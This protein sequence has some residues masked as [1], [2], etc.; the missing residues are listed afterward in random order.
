[1]LTYV[2]FL[3]ERMEIWHRKEVLHLSKP[4]TDDPV[5]R[6]AS[7]CNIYRELDTVTRFEVSLLTGVPRTDVY[8]ICLL[9][10]S[11]SP[12][13]Y[14]ALRAGT[15]GHLDPTKVV[16]DSMVGWES[17]YPGESQ[18]GWVLSFKE[19]LDSR[20]DVLV[21]DIQSCREAGD[22]C[23]VI[24]HSLDP[25]V[26]Y[27][28]YP[29]FYEF[30]SYEIY[31]SLT[32]CRWF[33]FTEDDFCVIGPGCRPALERL[34]RPGAEWPEFENLYLRVRDR[35]ETDPDFRWIPPEYQPRD[36]T[37]RKFTRRTLEHSLCEWRKYFQICEGRPPRRAYNGAAS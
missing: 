6:R 33:P 1:M 36:P 21:D 2:E 31:T 9:R 13:T 24:S 25:G 19:Q 22:V 3:K 7:F 37:P 11:N 12:D 5:L 10:H 18:A 16:D 23:E 26:W 14:R 15:L 29:H 35:L 34:T 20:I 27:E 8:A 30:W 28:P 32:Y 17:N 4:W